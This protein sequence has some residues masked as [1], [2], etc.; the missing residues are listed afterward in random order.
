MKA[1]FSLKKLLQH[2][3]GLMGYSFSSHCNNVRYVHGQIT[4]V[5]FFDFL[6]V[7]LRVTMH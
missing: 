7:L 5:S 6:P 2:L 4:L 1:L 3:G